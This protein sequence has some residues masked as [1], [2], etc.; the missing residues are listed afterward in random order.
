MPGMDSYTRAGLTFDVVDEGPADG[1]AVILLHGFPETSA[2]WRRVVPGLVAAGYRVLA[3]DQRGYSPRARPLG[4]RA[5]ALPELVGDVLALADFAGA[6]RFHLV[7][8]DW[9]GAVAWGVATDHADRLRTLTVLSTPHPQAMQRAFVSSTQGLKSWYMLLFQIPV[10]PERLLL[11]AD[12]RAFRRAM[13]G[14]GLPAADMTRY[15][16]VLSAPG[17]LTAALNW[18]RALPFSV[19]GAARPAPVAVPT[20]Y[21]WS[22]GDVALGRKAAELTRRY[23]S[24]AYRFEI[25]DGVSHWIPEQAPDDVIRLFLDQARETGAA[26]SEN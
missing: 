13:E 11:A 3:P 21:V 23:V 25:L 16:A 8:H 4:R 17:A 2:S 15:L 14:S 18:Y 7:G 19:A 26:P 10:V 12:G 5:Y 1:E 20:T 9:G 22:T 24:G 6:P